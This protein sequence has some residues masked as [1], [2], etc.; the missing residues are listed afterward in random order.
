[1][2]RSG[3]VSEASLDMAAKPATSSSLGNQ[4]ILD[5]T[6]VRVRGQIMLRVFN[7]FLSFSRRIS[8]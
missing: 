3:V 7:I 8:G 5:S 4:N 1:M 6:E 2:D